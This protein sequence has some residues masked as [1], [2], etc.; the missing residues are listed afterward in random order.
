MTISFASLN[1]GLQR[2][3]ACSANGQRRFNAIARGVRRAFQEAEV[4]AIGLVEVGDKVQGLPR[5]QADQLVDT[6]RP[7]TKDRALC[8]CS[9]G[10]PPVHA[11]EQNRIQD[12]IHRRSA[13]SSDEKF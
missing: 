3:Q 4:D 7:H 13:R 2:E 12:Q 11:A 8:S 6:I 9:R 1:I 10:R 5:Q